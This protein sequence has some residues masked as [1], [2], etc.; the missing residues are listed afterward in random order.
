MKNIIGIWPNLFRAVEV[1]KTGNFSISVWFDKQ[2]YPNA[3]SDYQT[4][5]DFCK[6]WFDNFSKKGNINIELT[7]PPASFFENEKH[8]ETIA[9]IEKRIVKSKLFALPVWK[10]DIGTKQLLKHAIEKLDL[11][12]SQ[13]DLIEKMSV[14]IA[15][16]DFSDSVR[17]QHV[18]EAIQYSFVYDSENKT[19]FENKV[20]IIITLK[21]GI[22]GIERIATDEEIILKDYDLGDNLPPEVKKDELGYFVESE[23]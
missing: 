17:A 4:I 7:K 14:V 13:I 9:D 5:K 21:N 18:A 16:M 23:L 2:E 10:P 8:F 11:S 3:E 20:M 15:Q 22:V 6:G 1:A 12:L 19:N